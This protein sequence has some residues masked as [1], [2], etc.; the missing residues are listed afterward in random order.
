[1]YQ[2]NWGLSMLNESVVVCEDFVESE[3]YPDTPAGRKEAVE[4][5]AGAMLA[6]MNEK[7]LLGVAGW[8]TV[9]WVTED[10]IPRLE[11]AV[12]K[13]A[14]RGFRPEDLVDIANLSMFIFAAY[15]KGML[16]VE[17]EDSLDEV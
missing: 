7:S 2:K 4:T 9:E 13:A 8:N 11:F 3:G 10:A 16:R 1:M 17:A 14:V 6:R 12:H 15:Q 5:F